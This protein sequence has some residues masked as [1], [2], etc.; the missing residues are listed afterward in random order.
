MNLPLRMSILNFINKNSLSS[1][2][3]IFFDLK[4]LYSKERQFSYS[5]LLEHLLNLE[6]NELIVFKKYDMSFNGKINLFY[7]ISENG[8]TFCK[9]YLKK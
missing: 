3:D 2:K 6:A 8:K 5:S 1:M 7:S 9:K 4:E